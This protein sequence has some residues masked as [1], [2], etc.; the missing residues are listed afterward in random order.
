MREPVGF[1]RMEAFPIK[2][3]ALKTVEAQTEIWK[4]MTDVNTKDSWKMSS[5][6]PWPPFERIIMASALQLHPI[7]H[8]DRDQ[9]WGHFFRRTVV[10]RGHMCTRI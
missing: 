8:S 9:K 10:V 2:R 3:M 7:A 4:P 6:T 1:H 5:S